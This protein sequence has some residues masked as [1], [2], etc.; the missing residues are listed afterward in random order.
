MFGFLISP[1][2]GKSFTSDSQ[3]SHDFIH[4]PTSNGESCVNE[5]GSCVNEM[6]RQKVE[7]PGFP[8]ILAPANF[9]QQ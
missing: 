9:N 5:I 3:D 2:A 7:I 6:Y 8:L 1:F 4:F